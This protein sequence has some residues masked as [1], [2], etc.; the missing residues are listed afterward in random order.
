MEKLPTNSENF[1]KQ[2]N[3]NFIFIMIKCRNADEQVYEIISE[4]VSVLS[5]WQ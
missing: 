2:W 5:V 4:W 3:Y 1:N